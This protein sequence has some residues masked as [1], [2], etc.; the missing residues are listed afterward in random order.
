M[1]RCHIG[2][3]PRS[4]LPQHTEHKPNNPNKNSFPTFRSHSLNVSKHVAIMSELARLVE[5]ENLLDVSQFEQ[6]RLYLPRIVVFIC[7]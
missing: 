4:T 3:H 5:K 2:P 6:A 1:P 7:T